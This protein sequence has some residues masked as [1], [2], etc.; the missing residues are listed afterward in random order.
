MLASTADDCTCRV[1]RRCAALHTRPVPLVQAH[2]PCNA[3]SPSRPQ[4]LLPTLGLGSHEGQAT[5]PHHLG[6][7]HCGRVLVGKWDLP[8]VHA[9]GCSARQPCGQPSEY[10][11]LR[12]CSSDAVCCLGLT[13]RGPLRQLQ[14]RLDPPAPATLSAAPRGPLRQLLPW[15]W[16]WQQSRQDSIT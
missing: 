13:P 8:H 1:V 4:R 10:D 11:P 7:W 2:K 3:N 5:S 9:H 12:A 14:P 15:Q 6:V 16:W